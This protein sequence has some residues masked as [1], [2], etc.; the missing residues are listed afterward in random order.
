MPY[1]LLKHMSFGMALLLGA[2]GTAAPVGLRLPGFFGNNMVLQRDLPVP[3]WG[4]AAPGVVVVVEFAGQ[5]VEATADASGKWVAKLAPMPAAGDG[6]ALAVRLQGETG[7]GAA[8]VLDNVVVGEVWLCSGQSNMEWSVGGTTNAQQEMA[9]AELPGIRHVKIAKL[10]ADLPQDDIKAAWAVCSPATVGGFTAVGFYFARQLHAELGVPIGLVGSNW[11][12][13]RIEPWT[14]PEGFH[15]VPE[16]QAIASKIDATLPS[17][18]AGRLAYQQALAEIEAWVPLAQTAVAAANNPPPMPSLPA[19]GTGI[20]DPTRLYNAMI[21]PLIPYALRGVIWY[22]GE[23][24]GGEGISYLHKTQALIEGWRHLW[25]Q[26]DF[27]FYYV[28]LANFQAA[29][30]VPAGGDGWARLREA[31]LQALQI[32]NTGMAVAIDIGEDNDIHPRNKQD[33]GSRLARWALAKTYGHEQWVPSG[34]LYRSHEVVDGSIRLSFDHVGGGLM[35][36]SKDGLAPTV[37]LPDGK[38]ARFAIAGADRQ[39]Q[40]AEATVDGDT[41]VVSSPAVP[42]PVAVRYAFSMNPSGANLYNR[43]GLPASPFRTD[44]W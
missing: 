35:V 5:T 43:E 33:V 37:E 15:A 8:L 42:E 1:R 20:Q 27:P 38:L 2:A 32:P 44:S 4:W 22:Q 11:G 40:W 39:W 12:G 23:S 41:V 30:D 10:A 13:T 31:Q 28:Q 24:N 18:E 36:G 3:I 34:P 26:G 14:A 21:H 25:G 16:L 17:T 6:Q 9:A 29:N 7:E 19:M